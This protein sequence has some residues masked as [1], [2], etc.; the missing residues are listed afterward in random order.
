MTVSGN[1]TKPTSR[2]RYSP[3]RYDS[4]SYKEGKG[5]RFILSG[6]YGFGIPQALPKYLPVNS[7][8][9]DKVLYTTP[10]A[11]SQWGA[12]LS[13]AVTKLSAWSWHVASSTSARRRRLQYLF[14]TADY[15]HPSGV[16]GY[17]PWM[18]RLG[19]DFLTTNNG[20]FYAI[21]RASRVYGSRIQGLYHLSS[22]RCKRTGDPDFPVVYTDRHGR[23]NYLRWFDVVMM[24]DL[25]EPDDIGNGVGFCA[26]DRAYDQI[27]QLSALEA[28]LYEKLTANSPTA[29]HLI[30]GIT[31]Q[32]IKDAIADAKEQASEED[33]VSYMGAVLITLL[34]PDGTPQVQ[35]IQLAGLPDNAT[36]SE[37]RD[38][39]DIVYANSLGMDINEIKPQGGQA[40]GVGASAQVMH[41]KAKGK[42]IVSFRQQFEH[43]ANWE[44]LDTRSK[45]YFTE[46][47]LVDEE[48]R[49]RIAA[50]YANAADKMIH[51]GTMSP[52]QGQEWMM[53]GDIIP[54]RF[55]GR[56]IVG[57]D[58]ADDDK[59]GL[60]DYQDSASS[61]RKQPVDSFVDPTAASKK[62]IPTPGP[63]GQDLPERPAP[64]MLDRTTSSNSRTEQPVKL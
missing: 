30:G 57:D 63:A 32:Q 12:A 41:Q 8:A 54:R 9:R 3:T 27:K 29:I 19:R 56:N 52:R 33:L 48:R 35:T 11:E 45:F 24:V 28:Y 39:A 25:P 16:W 50:T 21:A 43:S 7:R 38:R 60:L 40:L 55:A 58:L 26:A 5:G 36:P 53:D 6:Q 15:G 4:V 2:A 10:R 17:V 64:E 51:N 14:L 44:V 1:G 59:A 62:Q 46:R 34:K 42:G 31:Q 47:D 61:T 22:L 23:E 49:A 13:I 20:S 18:E 37:V